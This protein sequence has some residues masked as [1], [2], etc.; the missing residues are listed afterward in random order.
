MTTNDDWVDGSKALFQ[1]FFRGPEAVS[2]AS[3]WL[4]SK[5]LKDFSSQTLY[6]FLSDTARQPDNRVT[7]YRKISKRIKNGAFIEDA[8]CLIEEDFEGFHD[9]LLFWSIIRVDLAKLSAVISYLRSDRGSF[10]FFAQENPRFSSGFSKILSRR[11][12][13]A[14][15]SIDNKSVIDDLISDG[16]IPIRIWGPSGDRDIWIEIYTHSVGSSPH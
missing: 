3:T 13:G 1:H 5:G 9:G 4:V 16:L 10:L 11:G 15:A 2:E 6:L 14:L 7:R 12:S 8:G